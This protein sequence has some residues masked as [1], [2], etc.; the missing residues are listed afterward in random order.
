MAAEG[1]GV[2]LVRADEVDLE[3]GLDGG[4][5]AGG[6][7]D[8][9]DDHAAVVVVEDVLGGALGGVEDAVLPAVLGFIVPGPGGRHGRLAG[10][11]LGFGVHRDERL[12]VCQDRETFAGFADVGAGLGEGVVVHAGEDDVLLVIGDD[13]DAGALL[14]VP[15]VVADPGVAEDLVAEAVF[16]A[17]DLGAEV[18]PGVGGVGGDLEGMGG[19]AE[20]DDRTATLEIGDNVVHFLGGKIEEA[21]EDEEQV[22]ILEG[23]E[24]GNPGRPGFDVT[25]GVDPED[26]GALEP[27]VLGENAGEGRAGFLG[28][29]FVVAGQEDDVLALAKAG[30]AFVDDG[31]AGVEAGQAEKGAEE[32]QGGFHGGKSRMFNRLRGRTGVLIREVGIDRA[33]RWQGL[34]PGGLA[35][36]DS[37]PALGVGGAEFGAL[38]GEDVV[39]GLGGFKRLGF[40]GG[41]LTV[42]GEK[43][44]SLQR[45]GGRVQA[46]EA[47]AD[48]GCVDLGE[49][50]D[51]PALHGAGELLAGLGK[52]AAVTGI[53]G[54]VADRQGEGELGIARVAGPGAGHPGGVGQEGDGLCLDGI[55]RGDVDHE[56]HVAAK[57]MGG[58]AGHVDDLGG[59]PLDRTGGEALGQGP[60]ELGGDADDAGVFPIRVVAVVVVDM[61]ADREGHAGLD[62]SDLGEELEVDA[63]GGFG[64]RGQR[65]EDVHEGE[66]GSLHGRMARLGA[67]PR[68]V[69]TPRSGFGVRGT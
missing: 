48:G 51:R 37:R 57:A 40:V 63:L 59:G 17:L 55:R 23:G 9:I 50:F 35:G 39:A 54:G 4:F 5:H 16:V 67:G 12:R 15:A 61:E 47:E 21:R 64:G 8:A 30:I 28:P 3:I 33:E 53:D 26:D 60:V 65:P 27:V 69:N 7:E 56:K 19:G 6:P 42:G 14:V 22:G 58:V 38:E 2:R 43:V 20:P 36:E 66:D 45:S 34:V 41:D 44:E 1:E 32:D 11:R 68:G 10:V 13:L 46:D 31:G 29:V 25:V 49:D 24:T 52:D 62:G 18:I